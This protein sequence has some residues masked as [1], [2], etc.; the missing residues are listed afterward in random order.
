MITLPGLKKAPKKRIAAILEPVDEIGE[1]NGDINEE[2]EEENAE[3][4]E[5]LGMI[6][7]LVLRLFTP[8]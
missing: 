4:A 5:D 6:L 2:D 1:V 8:C 7:Y 3:D